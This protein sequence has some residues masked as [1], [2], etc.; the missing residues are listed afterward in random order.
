MLQN[1]AFARLNLLALAGVLNLT[2]D[3]NPSVNNWGDP[4]LADSGM[5]S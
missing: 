1:L 4:R 5:L 2:F 3:L